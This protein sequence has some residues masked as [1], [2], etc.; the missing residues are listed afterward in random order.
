MR[1]D[2]SLRHRR[3]HPS[4]PHARRTHGKTKL[5]FPTAAT[6]PP[7]SDCSLARSTSFPSRN[8]SACG[9]GRRRPG[10]P[11]QPSKS[12][13]ELPTRVG[14]AE[15]PLSRCR[16]GSRRH[17]VTRAGHDADHRNQRIRP[18]IGPAR[19]MA[20]TLVVRSSRC[21]CT[22]PLAGLFTRT[23]E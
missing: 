12:S 6:R 4:P 19:S 18:P 8:S 21:T 10:C 14:L 2:R 23:S 7:S 20:T 1:R 5:G 17:L 22:S 15:P 16:Q 3:E 11:Q 13:R 9:R